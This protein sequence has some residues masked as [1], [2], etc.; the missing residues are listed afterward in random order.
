MI[1]YYQILGLNKG[2]SLVEVKKAYRKMA[3]KYHPDHN[4]DPGAHDRF[5]L[6]GEAYS[7]LSNP[8]RKARY[9]NGSQQAA[10]Q[11]A[12]QQQYEQWVRRERARARQKA[13]Q[14]ANTP[15]EKFKAKMLGGLV[16]VTSHLLNFVAFTMTFMVLYSGWYYVI[17]PD[18]EHPVDWALTIFMTVLGLILGYGTY[19]I[20]RDQR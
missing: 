12:R 10:A 2:A 20:L 4:P 15:Y 1:D 6:I 18:D 13:E 11:R 3:L 17:H 5:I 8:N 7:Y 19:L 9:D 14:D 16:N